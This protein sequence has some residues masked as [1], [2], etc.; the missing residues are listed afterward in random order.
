MLSRKWLSILLSF[1]ILFFCTVVSFSKETIYHSKE[2]HFSIRIPDNLVELTPQY[3][4]NLDNQ[5]LSRGLLPSVVYREKLQ[6]YDVAFLSF[7]KPETIEQKRT[8]LGIEIVR[9]EHFTHF[10][11]PYVRIFLNEEE[12]ETL[13]REVAKKIRDERI[14]Q[15]IQERDI[16]I[17]KERFCYYFSF[18]YTLPGE[19]KVEEFWAGF[20]SKIHA[21]FLCLEILNPPED[22][23]CHAL[24]TD[25]VNSFNFDPIYR[26]SK[27]YGT[28]RVLGE[29]LLS[30]ILIVLIFLTIPRVVAIIQGI[31][32]KREKEMPETAKKPLP[33]P[34][35]KVR[36]ETF[37]VRV[38][39][40][41]PSEITSETEVKKSLEKLRQHLLE[42][43]KKNRKVVPY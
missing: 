18:S 21:V 24:F 29:A 12:V 7:D 36:P 43:I 5:L 34:A 40:F 38:S 14:A 2:A 30:L 22:L 6:N 27:V 26:Y 10:Y 15:N 25:L 33:L 16:V 8:I 19:R 11:K 20:L 37:H 17:D 13:R 28:I 39:E 1:F 4:T 42:Q 31:F 32:L 23:D 41:F 35:S 9:Y 3:L